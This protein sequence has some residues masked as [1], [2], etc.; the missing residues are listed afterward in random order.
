MAFDASEQLIDLRHQL[1]RYPELS[2]KEGRT[3]QTI[4][5]YLREN[6][7]PDELVEK[8]GG[9]GLLAIYEGK[10][11]GPTVLFRCELDALPIEEEGVEGH[12]SEHSGIS[13]KCGHDGHMTVLTGLGTLMA[14]RRPERGRVLLLYQPA[15]E[16]GEGAAKVLEDPR[17]RP[18]LPD[19]AY[20]LHNLPGYPEGSVIT[21]PGIFA[22]ASKGKEVFL[23]GK[24]SHA[25]EPQNGI[26]PA[27]AMADIV[28]EYFFLSQ[29][30]SFEDFVLSTVIHASLGS[31]SF[32]TSPGEAEV[33]ATLRSY[34]EDDM[35]F[36]TEKAE[37]IAIRE[38]RENDLIVSFDEKEVFPASIND[39]EAND[40]VE[41]AAVDAGLEHQRIR[42]PFKWSED[43][44]HFLHYCPGVLF[45]LGSGEEQPDLHNP[46]FDFPDGA[47][48]KG[49]RIFEGIARKETGG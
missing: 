40:L 7:P 1:H 35:S 11:E 33:R 49:M 27:L 14:K 24:T 34:R 25:G 42:A 2:G 3:A 17:F 20:A 21:K 46:D 8:L 6:A 32:G 23:Y 19:K 4:A 38:A 41:E 28:K 18:Y 31:I 9:D 12:A 5:S 22:S 39:E 15:E 47:I 45:G 29:K 10:E 30:E 26:S 37:E 43:F 48:E 16:T 13:H 44:G 36:L